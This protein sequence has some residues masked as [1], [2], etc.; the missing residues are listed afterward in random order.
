MKRTT[1]SISFYIKRKKLLSNGEAPIMARI[2]VNRQRAEFSTK[3]SVLPDDWDPARGR[4]GKRTKKALSLNEYL[5]EVWG[6]IH[7]ARKQLEHE[8]KDVNAQDVMNRYLG[9]DAIRIGILDLYQEHNDTLKERIDRGVAFGTWERH[10]TS[11]SHF[12]E[13]LKQKYRKSDIHCNRINKTMLEEYYH[14]LITKRECANN[15]AIKYL[16]NLNK[17][18][19]IA[20]ERDYIRKNPHFRLKLKKDEVEKEFLTDK[21]LDRLM[22]KE[23][24]TERLGEV[25]DTFVFSCLTGLAFSDI[26]TLKK[27]HLVENNGQTW[28]HKPRQKTNIMSTIPLLP[29][30]KSILTKYYVYALA[31]SYLLPV[32]SNQKMNE[33]LKEIAT[34]CEINKNLTTHTARH[35]FATTVTLLLG[36]R[37]EHVSKMMGH[38]NI[39]MT[40]HYAKI[41]DQ[42]IASDMK[43]HV[44]GRY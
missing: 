23:F 13:F 41:L 21:E 30:A 37:I 32:K 14:F 35:T 27:E 42:N 10:T 24:A 44:E 38:T 31:T 33:Y 6:S 12:G 16:S 29:K 19:N 9:T 36:V 17:I 18:L 8:G 26:K 15:T 2:T 28:V 1:F 20:I 25:R 4:S 22:A 11:R 43:A 7:D 3:R 5:E 39:T 34:L 40:Q